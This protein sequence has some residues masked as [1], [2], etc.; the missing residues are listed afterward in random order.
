VKT[1]LNHAQEAS[2]P[3]ATP[4]QVRIHQLKLGV[5]WNADHLRVARMCDGQSPQPARR[6]SQPAFL[7]GP[8]KQKALAEGRQ[9]PRSASTPAGSQCPLAK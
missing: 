2:T 5:D 6:F 7:K 9:K 8:K 4:A 3:N 1:K